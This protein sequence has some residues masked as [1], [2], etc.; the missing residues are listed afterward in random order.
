M[1]VFCGV[2]RLEVFGSM[3]RV[4][5]GFWVLYRGVGFRCRVY[6]LRVGGS[7]VI[8]GG[9]G[10]AGKSGLGASLGVKVLVNPEP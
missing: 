2:Q 8:G 7:Q 4:C 3:R 10:G 6:G 1:R 5:G 9:G